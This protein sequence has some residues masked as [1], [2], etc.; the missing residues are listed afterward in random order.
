MRFIIVMM[1]VLCLAEW[2]YAHNT[3][4]FIRV[5]D[6]SVLES[7]VAVNDTNITFV[8]ESEI[9]HRDTNPDSSLTS[10]GNT[11]YGGL[12]GTGMH[13]YKN[14]TTKEIAAYV[15]DWQLLPARPGSFWKVSKSYVPSSARVTAVQTYLNGQTHLETYEGAFEIPIMYSGKVFLMSSIR[16][17]VT[18][19]YTLTVSGT[20]RNMSVHYG[21]NRRETC[22]EA[23]CEYEIPQGTE[24]TVFAGSS[25]EAGTHTLVWGS[26][27]SE[28]STTPDEHNSPP[29]CSVTM[30]ADKTVT[31]TWQLTATEE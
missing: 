7:D 17:A 21:A 31:A 9:E 27:C 12:L 13:F 3:H 2:S 10:Y 18:T 22:R 30:D 25:P 6:K 16:A 26:T 28:A 4:W 5:M 20:F 23:S 14:P 11:V 15:L 19:N 29:S 8:A 1:L 24:V